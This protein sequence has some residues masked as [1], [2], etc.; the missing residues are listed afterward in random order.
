VSDLVI[1]ASVAI[2]WLTGEPGSEAAIALLERPLHAP[3]LLCAECSNAL[4]KKVARHEISAPEAEVLAAT[5]Q[6]AGITLHAMRH[7][8]APATQLACA[9]EQPAYACFYLALARTLGFPLVT[10]DD[11]LIRTVRDHS[12]GDLSE[13]VLPLASAP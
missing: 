12:P 9:L 10:A 5:L 2:R 13:L 8:L 7:L 6:A 1:D 11:R 3:D 4:W